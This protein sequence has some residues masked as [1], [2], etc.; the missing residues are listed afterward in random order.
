MAFLV[1]WLPS[2]VVG[3]VIAVNAL[4]LLRE[5][6]RSEDADHPTRVQAKVWLV[7][8]PKLT[9]TRGDGESLRVA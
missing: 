9:Q 5:L 6:R 4:R 2:L 7:G 1:P 8:D 3:I